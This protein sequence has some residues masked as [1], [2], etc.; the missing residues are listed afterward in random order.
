MLSRTGPVHQR[1]IRSPACGRCRCWT[2]PG[3]QVR[4]RRALLRS[5][6]LWAIPAARMA[7][8]RTSR[9]GSRTSKHPARSVADRLRR[10]NPSENELNAA[11]VAAYQAS[12]DEGRPLSE[13]RLAA[14]YGKTSRRWARNR[15]AEARQ[16]P[17]SAMAE[18]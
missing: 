7:P 2:R 3:P 4:A 15:I 18:P 1:T 8:G 12:L 11:A 13:R 16:I 14:M 5:P 9:T 17:A 6:P 10:A